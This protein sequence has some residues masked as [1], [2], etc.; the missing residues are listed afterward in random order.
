MN[1]LIPANWT[2]LLA[3]LAVALPLSLAAQ[4]VTAPPVDDNL[5]HYLQLLSSDFNSVK[6]ELVNRIMKLSENDARKFWPIY[7][8]YEKAYGKQAIKRAEF[9][10]EFTQSHQDGTLNNAHARSLARR[11]FKAQRARLDLQEK[12][13][14]KIESALSSMQAGQFLQ[15]ENQLNIF[16]DMTIASEMPLVGEKQE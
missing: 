6:V 2:R 12:Y 7:H 15:I 3:V 5:Q 1:N 16:I 9:I 4:G 8:E 11:W 10:A 14:R 13:H